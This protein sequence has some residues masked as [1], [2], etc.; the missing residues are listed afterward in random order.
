MAT[1]P[2]TAAS[3]PADTNNFFGAMAC[4]GFKDELARQ[5]RLASQNSTRAT[6]LIALLAAADT[7][8]DAEIA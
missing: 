8:L 1:Q 3:L 6:A 5:V 4:S 2:I 7:L